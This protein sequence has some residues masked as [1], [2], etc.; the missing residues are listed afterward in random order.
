MAKRTVS[1]DQYRH[2]GAYERL[3][4]ALLE[5]A[6]HE[7]L[8]KPLAFWVMPTDRRLPVAFLDRKLRSILA[9]TLSE[10]HETPGIGQKKIGGLLTL[11]QRALQSGPPQADFGLANGNRKRRGRATPSGF[12]PSVVS[13]EL[14]AQWRETAKRCDVGGLTLGY[15]APTLQSLPTVIWDTPLSE[16]MELTLSEIRGLKTHGSKRVQAILEVFCGVHEA[17]STTTLQEHIEISL[18]PKFISPVLKWILDVLSSGESPSAT[19]LHDNIAKPFLKQIDVDLGKQI[20]R[21][22]ASRVSLN[23]NAP[24]VRKQAERL[25]VTRARVYQLLD[26]CAKA[27]DIRWPE[28][29]WLLVPLGSRLAMAEDVDALGGYRSLYDLFY[30]SDRS[31]MREL[32]MV[33]A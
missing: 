27:M 33:H 10:L 29:R 31:A 6:G 13:E 25:G 28:G 18:R 2:F 5:D 15:L 30:P 32:D 22:A 23:R 16:Y 19:E 24:T 17:L 3:R 11:L 21:L 12:D 4:S 7:R 8:E 26:D 9:C 1:T 14:W 20:A